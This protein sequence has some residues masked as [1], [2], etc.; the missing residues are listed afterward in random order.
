[1]LLAHRITAVAVIVGALALAGCWH[2][3]QQLGAAR[4]EVAEAQ[5]TLQIVQDQRKK[6]RATSVFREKLRAA[7][8]AQA[9]SQA[10]AVDRA[11]VAQPEWAETPVPQEVQDALAP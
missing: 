7:E 5:K 6:D 11:L 3:S 9:A 1:M 8:A 4:A 10:I 2:L